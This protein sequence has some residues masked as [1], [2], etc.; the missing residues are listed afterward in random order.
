MN[1]TVRKATVEDVSMILH[2]RVGMFTDMGY[3]VGLIARMQEPFRAW[4][5][6]RLHNGGYHGWLAVNANLQVIAGA[7]L[8]LNDWIPSPM[9]L[10]GRRGYVLNV[11]TEPEYR[12]Q[13]IARHLVQETI[14]YCRAQ[15]LST[16]VLHA[17]EQGRSIYEAL[18]FEMTNEMRMRLE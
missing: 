6:E 8:W 11:Y 3:D 4:V 7:G 18:G 17:S 9:L 5:F 1:Y 16:V 10:S 14:D 15:G 2:H 12:K 13:G